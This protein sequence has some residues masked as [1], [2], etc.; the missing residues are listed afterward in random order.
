MSR[1]Y[2][3]FMLDLDENHKPIHY[4]K[5][6]IC[7][8]EWVMGHSSPVDYFSKRN[9]KWDKKPWY[10]PT[11]VYKQMMGQGRRARVKNAMARK[12]YENI[13]V[14]KKEDVWNWT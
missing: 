7:N 6:K 5:R 11:Q 14:F 1:T 12:D 2:R 9:Q 13:P 3:T 8:R 10:K 4:R